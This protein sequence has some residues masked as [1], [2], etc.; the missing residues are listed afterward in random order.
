MTKS[1]AAFL[2]AALF[3]AFLG[4]TGG[5]RGQDSSSAL[6][7]QIEAP[8]SPNRQGHDPH[9]L[10]EIIAKYRKTKTYKYKPETII[11]IIKRKIGIK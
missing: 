9:T 4:S 11:D 1:K 10:Q 7:A 2:T 3:A 5:A 6:I 8:Q